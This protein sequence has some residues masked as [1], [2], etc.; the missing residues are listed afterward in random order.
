M[1]SALEIKNVDTAIYVVIQKSSKLIHINYY[2]QMENVI[3]FG[4][5]HNKLTSFNLSHPK[6]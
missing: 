5:K 6:A 3:L 2:L 1:Y 4:N